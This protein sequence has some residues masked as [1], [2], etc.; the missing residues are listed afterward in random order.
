MQR[1]TLVFTFA[2]LVSACGPGDKTVSFTDGAGNPASITFK[3]DDHQVEHRAAPGGRRYQ[4]TRAD[5]QQCKS[6]Q[7][8]C[9]LYG[10]LSVPSRQLCGLDLSGILRLNQR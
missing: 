8:E 7:Y 4:P 1:Q 2:G 5:N 10:Q 6:D 9:D 3:I